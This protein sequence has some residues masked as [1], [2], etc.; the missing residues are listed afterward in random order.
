MKDFMAYFMPV[1]LILIVVVLFTIFQ[2]KQ[3][4]II[5]NKCTGSSITTM[6]A[7]FANFRVTNCK[8]LNE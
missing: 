5:F 6:E 3:E 4:A 2:A 7:M 8:G 1:I